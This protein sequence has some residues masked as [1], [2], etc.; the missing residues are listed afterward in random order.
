MMKSM[1]SDILFI[2]NFTIIKSQGF[3]CMND[4]LLKGNDKGGKADLNVCGIINQFVCNYLSDLKQMEAVKPSAYMGARVD[5]G[6]SGATSRLTHCKEANHERKN[7]FV[8]G[9][10]QYRF[11]IFSQHRTE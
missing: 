11:D 9:Y 5:G 2:N 6:A 4:I 1:T 3:V 10:P 8:S 7:R